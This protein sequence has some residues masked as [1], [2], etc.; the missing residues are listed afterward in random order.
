MIKKLLIVTLFLLVIQPVLLFASEEGKE[1]IL[2]IKFDAPPDGSF[3]DKPLHINKTIKIPAVLKKNNVVMTQSTIV[4]NFPVTLAMLVKAIKIDSKQVT[5]QFNLLNY[6]F[7]KN[8]SV[9]TAPTLVLK[10]GQAG[11]MQ[12]QAFKLK[13]SASWVVNLLV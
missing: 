3:Y 9:I 6:G 4:E 13:V 8:G 1:L 11:E 12:N 5:L 7:K 2:N 10:N